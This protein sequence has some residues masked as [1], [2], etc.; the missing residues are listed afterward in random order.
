MPFIMCCSSD[1][2]GN[3]GDG[4]NGILATSET[5]SSREIEID[6]SDAFDLKDA[7]GVEYLLT[8]TCC[9]T[10][11]GVKASECIGGD[12]QDN[13]VPNNGFVVSM[14]IDG[15]GRAFF[16]VTVASVLAVLRRCLRGRPRLRFSVDTN[17]FGDSV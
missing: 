8:A 15:D 17:S 1:G 12:V 3:N 14:R 10:F 2:D 6:D 4:G 13:V 16:G 5:V 11:C 9:G 7:F